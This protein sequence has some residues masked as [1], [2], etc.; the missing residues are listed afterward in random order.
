MAAAVPVSFTDLCA[1]HR[2]DERIVKAWQ[3]MG[4]ETVADM[5]MMYSSA[6]AVQAWVQQLHL[7][8]EH[9][10]PAV[11]A[12][13]EAAGRAEEGAISEGKELARG[14]PL[15]VV[16]VPTFRN[17]DVQPFPS[18]YRRIVPANLNPG[19]P[20]SMVL[21]A[22]TKTPEQQRETA[23]RQRNAE[24]FWVEFQAIA[25]KSTRW[26]SYQ[27]ADSQQSWQ[28]HFFGPILKLES[29][30]TNN[31]INSLRRYKEF[32]VSIPEPWTPK[33]DQVANFLKGVTKGGP[34]AAQGV[35]NGLDFCA[36]TLGVDLMLKDMLVEQYGVR[37]EG[38]VKRGLGGQ[39]MLI[40]LAM[41]WSL[42]QLIVTSTGAVSD[43][44]SMA[45]LFVMLGLRWIHFARWTPTLVSGRLIHG[46][47]SRGKTRRN[48][49]RPPVPAAAP[50]TMFG[51]KDIAGRFTKVWTRISV[52]NGAPLTFAPWDYDIPRSGSLEDTSV[53]I[54]Q[55]LSYERFLHLLKGV[56]LGMGFPLEIVC[57][58]TSYSFRRWMA[59]YG[60]VIGL[61]MTERDALGGWLENT[62]PATAAS[63]S[64]VKPAQMQ[65]AVHYS[66]A[67]V[68]AQGEAKLKVLAG[69][70][71]AIR[72]IGPENMTTAT[73]DDIRKRRPSEAVL[74]LECKSNK[75]SS[76]R[77]WSL[78]DV[79]KAI[80]EG[81]SAEDA[82]ELAHP[83]ELRS[84]ATSS[85]QSTTD[86]DDEAP[87]DAEE[88]LAIHADT[89][90]VRWVAPA[91]SQVLHLMI[92]D[93]SGVERP[94][95]RRTMFKNA[96]V[97][98][99]LAAAVATGKPWH[100]V[101]LRALPARAKIEIGTAAAEMRDLDME[102][103]DME[104]PDKGGGPS[105]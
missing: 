46:M 42:D 83:T 61:D 97:E 102:N 99:G 82:I 23:A 67:K 73:I 25:A 75:W 5:G 66:D 47:V 4:V 54:A 59:T 22:K 78:E 33:A 39:A 70:L 35:Y 11:T 53:P 105:S 68:T 1:Q 93:G 19:P 64:K 21:E 15:P 65:M 6:E 80:A 56:F 26:T 94:A 84:G 87:S 95:C 43:F 10:V 58:L 77:S 91:K 48:G 71:Y 32:A 101:C 24:K 14:R 9:T 55:E 85:E 17:L 38:P 60:D 13:V 20:S 28:E 18:K 92:V 37:Q 100:S 40:P 2:V 7:E 8:D 31:Y 16:I 86:D 81:P 50:R 12:W 49:V 57:R 90:S 45:L 72:K 74:K 3:D 89:A 44:A 41:L 34:T 96:V 69:V 36:R 79:K 29:R 104:S 63:C 98:E 30:T 27:E 76:Q 88:E 103:H 51:T 62:A 52:A